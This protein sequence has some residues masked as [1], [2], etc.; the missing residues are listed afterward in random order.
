M[1]TGDG[2]LNAGDGITFSGVSIE[3]DTACDLQPHL[4][5]HCYLWSILTFEQCSDILSYCEDVVTFGYLKWACDCFDNHLTFEYL[6]R[7]NRNTV[8]APL[9]KQNEYLW[10]LTLKFIFTL[11]NALVSFAHLQL[12]LDIA[13][14]PLLQQDSNKKMNKTFPSVNSRW[15]HIIWAKFM[16]DTWHFKGHDINYVEQLCIGHTCF[17]NRYHIDGC[18][19]YIIGNSI[20]WMVRPYTVVDGHS[21][22]MEWQSCLITFQWY[23]SFIAF[24]CVKIQQL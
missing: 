22:L 6:F 10:F 7:V 5:G 9:K 12:F 13:K 14:V 17:D 19:V 3:K 2:S 18:Y 21:Q 8:L 11:I 16:N 20:I 23:W 15:P 4:D 1:L 24:L